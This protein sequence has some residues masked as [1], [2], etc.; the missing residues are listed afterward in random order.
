MYITKTFNK[1]FD[2]LIKSSILEYSKGQKTAKQVIQLLADGETYI[3]GK[4]L[5]PGCDMTKETKQDV[6]EIMSKIS[7]VEED[8]LW[9]VYDEV[10]SEFYEKLK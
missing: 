6:I 4:P 3:N 9:S 8:D 2:T 5:Y 10:Y 7:G 1:E